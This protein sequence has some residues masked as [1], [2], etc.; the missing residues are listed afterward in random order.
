M[1]NLVESQMR[2]GFPLTLFWVGPSLDLSQVKEKRKKKSKLALLSLPICFADLASAP[3]AWT[4]DNEWALL[5]CMVFMHSNVTQTSSISDTIVGYR[6]S[7]LCPSTRSFHG[8]VSQST[9]D[10]RTRW[11]NM[12]VNSHQVTEMN[13][14]TICQVRIRKTSVCKRKRN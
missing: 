12:D 8:N 3:L 6:P 9:Q 5:S 11:M 1:L 13:G 7:V 4:V 2:V 14:N 10:E